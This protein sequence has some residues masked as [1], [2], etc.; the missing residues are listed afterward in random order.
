[1]AH[2][3]SYEAIQAVE[4]MFLG[5]QPKRVSVFPNC[6]YS[7]PQIASIG[8][9][10]RAAQESGCSYRVGRFP[11]RISGKALAHGEPEGFVKLIIGDPEGELLGA[12]IIGA[13]ATEMVAELAVAM[14]LEAT[15]QEIEATIHAH[16]TLSEAVHEA[17][18]AAFGEAI[19]M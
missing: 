5:I 3:A 6:T 14:T 10:E 18:S 4:G 11:F 17:S 7:Q 9:T 13:E 1:L 15:Y 19:H 2:V 12:H 16:P 8:L